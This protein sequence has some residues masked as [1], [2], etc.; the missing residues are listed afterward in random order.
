MDEMPGPTQQGSAGAG[1]GSS[2]SENPSDGVSMS[3]LE[4]IVPYPLGKKQKRRIQVPKV[5]RV[6]LTYQDLL[7]ED[8]ELKHWLD[9]LVSDHQSEDK[10]NDTVDTQYRKFP[11][12][13][14]SM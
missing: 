11:R 8:D 10:L 4:K 3:S 14:F 13:N 7:E 6:M 1:P 2:D 5:A 12:P 9:I